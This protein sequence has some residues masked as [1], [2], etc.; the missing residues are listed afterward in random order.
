[1]PLK[2]IVRLEP[3]LTLT[4]QR[5]HA[6]VSCRRFSLG[7]LGSAALSH[8]QPHASSQERSTCIHRGM[9]R[10]VLKNCRYL[11]MDHF[12]NTYSALQYC[13]VL[14]RTY[15]TSARL[16][17]RTLCCTGTSTVLCVPHKVRLR[18]LAKATPSPTRHWGLAASPSLGRGNR[19]FYSMCGSE[20][21]L[22][23][24]GVVRTPSF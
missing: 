24:A 15:S 2:T 4:I 22:G 10:S 16:R 17:N 12:Q 8:D 11:D 20:R 23:R 6:Q 9:Y 3:P 13:T 1:M 7:V 19:E 21:G 5:N 14:E 18:S